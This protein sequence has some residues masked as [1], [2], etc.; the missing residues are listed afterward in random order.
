MRDDPSI[1]KIVLTRSR[2]V[3]LDGENV[4]VVPLRSAEGQRMLARSGHVFVQTDP[5]S[6]IIFSTFRSSPGLN[7]TSSVRSMI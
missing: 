6:R 5:R 3:L 7:P 4:V 2:T 1:K